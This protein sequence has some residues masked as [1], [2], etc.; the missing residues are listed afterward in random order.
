MCYCFDD[1]IK[2]E[3]FD[4]V[5]TLI[6]EKSHGI[7]LICD[8]SY[9][10]LNGSKPLHI[11]FDK[12]DGFIRI[13][14]GT[15]YFVLFGFEKYDAIYNR[16]RYLVS[17]K[18]SIRY[19]FFFFFF[20]YYVKCKVDSYNSLPIENILTLHD[21]IILIESVETTTIIYF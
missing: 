18:S 19:T 12:I 3:D 15:R 20:C 9:K 7:I 4:I 5:N 1:I 13:Y 16:I 21:V 6:D 2:L 14:D 10:T 11:I 8:I 17:L